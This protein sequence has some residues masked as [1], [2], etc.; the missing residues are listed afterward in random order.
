MILTIIVM[1]FLS[2]I[3][4]KPIIKQIVIIVELSKVRYM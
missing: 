2:T 3:K 4:L 1:S